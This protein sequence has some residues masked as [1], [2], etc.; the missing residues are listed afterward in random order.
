MDKAV[1]L[2][3]SCSQVG[4]ESSHKLCLFLVPGTNVCATGKKGTRRERLQVHPTKSMHEHEP[5][6]R[7]RIIEH[8]EIAGHARA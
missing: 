1:L 4:G 6:E 5:S 2:L 3:P 7:H 8:R